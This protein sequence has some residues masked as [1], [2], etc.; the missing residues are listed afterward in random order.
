MWA[1]EIRPAVQDGPTGNACDVYPEGALF[2]YRPVYRQYLPSVFVVFASS[3]GRM[4]G[5]LLEICYD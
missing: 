2:E 4:L 3:S 5:C 1:L